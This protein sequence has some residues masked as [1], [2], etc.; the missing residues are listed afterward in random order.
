M[1]YI[2]RRN[3]I[4]KE[5]IA[6]GYDRVA[7]K[8]GTVDLYYDR[9]LRLH[10]PYRGK[11]LD[12]G[13]GGGHLLKLLIERTAPY[14]EKLEQYD[15][16]KLFFYGIDISEELCRVAKKENP[17]AYIVQGDAEAL[18]YE[19]STFDFVFSTGS[20]EH[21]VDIQK[22][23]REVS[24]VL[25]PGGIFIITVPNRDWLQYNFYT[26]IRLQKRFQPVDDHYFWYLEL[27]K[28]L[29]DN[30]F[31][32]SKYKGTDCLFYYGWKHTLEQMAAYFVPFL[33]R[34]MKHHIVKCINVK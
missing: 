20:F 4:T 19:N 2:D 29:E 10:H 16:E 11:I 14:A 27:K 23:I 13:C 9:C 1:I 33:Y 22:A 6:K 15:T 17:S 25:K 7:R 3:T 34:K 18:P 30:H 31:V 26:E 12:I 8:I 21:V 5:E 28:L 32:I 24:R